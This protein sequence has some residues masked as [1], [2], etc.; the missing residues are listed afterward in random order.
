[1]EKRG[2]DVDRH[3]C[4]LSIN[5]WSKLNGFWWIIKV[6]LS[7]RIVSNKSRHVFLVLVSVARNETTFVHPRP[8]N[9]FIFYFRRV[10]SA[11]PFVRRP[12]F[13]GRNM[14]KCITFFAGKL[15]ISDGGATGIV[16]YTVGV[17]AP[18]YRENRET[19]RR[20]LTLSLPG[21][22]CTGRAH[23]LV[24]WT[25]NFTFVYVFFLKNKLCWKKN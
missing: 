1:M 11:L 25:T 14:N 19:Q 3:P 12:R 20:L 2:W 13:K 21:G 15:S 6:T 22:I 5:V 17:T 10:S 24:C 8:Q 18:G 16:C 4:H 9:I 7:Q 23:N